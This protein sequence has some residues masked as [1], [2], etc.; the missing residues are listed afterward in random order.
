MA[1][2]LEFAF[3]FHNYA[4]FDWENDIHELFKNVASI[5]FLL[6][7]SGLVELLRNTPK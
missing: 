7:N 1:I 6:I 3:G 4:N 5:N 2:A